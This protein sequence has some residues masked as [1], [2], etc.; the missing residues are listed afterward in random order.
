M[1]N[2]KLTHH[3]GDTRASAPLLALRVGG[4]TFTDEHL[5]DAQLAALRKG[6][7]LSP[8]VQPQLTVDG[9]AFAGADAILRY[10]GNLTGLYPGDPAA[11]LAVD[12]MLCALQDL[13]TAKNEAGPSTAAA[14]DTLLT[15]TPGPFV[16]A[17]G[18][19]IADIQ[20]FFAVAEGSKDVFGGFKNITRCSDAVEGHPKVKDVLQETGK[21]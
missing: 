17:D 7:D 20:L 3:V 12:E 11:A 10:C 4:V 14:I 5:T 2:L 9:R 8:C 13:H 1:T 16:L 6:G 21:W 19:S 18:L 15:V